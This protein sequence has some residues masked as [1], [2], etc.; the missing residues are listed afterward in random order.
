VSTLAKVFVVLVLVLAIAF[1]FM[2]LTLYSKRVD[3]KDR[4][5]VEKKA[6]ADMEA[7]L[8]G[9]IE[10]LSK[11]LTDKKR[12][13]A[14]KKQTVD[15]ITS[16]I[17]E[18]DIEIKELKDDLLESKQQ[19]AA[20]EVLIAKQRTELDRRHSQ[21]DEMHKIVQNQQRALTVAKENE[22]QSIRE[23]IDMENQ[24]NTKIQQYRDLTKEKAKIERELSHQNWVVQRLI[25]VGVPVADIVYSDRNVVQPE[26]PIHAKVLAVDKSVNLVMLS[27]GSDDGVQRGSTFTVYRKDQYIGKV[28]VERT[29]RDMC[30]A[31]ILPVFLGPGKEIREGDNA[32]NRVY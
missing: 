22:Q 20:K 29:F 13:L 6:K 15:D 4:W 28:E 14:L 21:I 1:C 24:L 2:T 32:A 9:K 25:E 31:R 7:L 16:R 27:V 23:K 8:N 30:S 17:K 26:K 5:E 19:G 10:D 18:R 11:E 12:E 3:F